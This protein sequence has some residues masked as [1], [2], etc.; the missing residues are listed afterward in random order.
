M[1]HS[2]DEYVWQVS[3]KSLH[4]AQKHCVTRNIC[5]RTDGRKDRSPDNTMPPLPVAGRG[6]TVGKIKG[7]TLL[8]HLRGFL[9]S[10]GD[11][12]NQTGYVSTAGVVV[13]AL[14][15]INEVNQRRARL[16]LRRVT[17]S[18]FNSRCRAFISV[19]NQPATQGQLSLPSLRGR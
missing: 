17:V 11:D 5:K 1:G 19:F 16:V 6:I 8:R 15:S 13:S 7:N 10:R 3:L 18:G 9:L 2:H 4:R 12:V 14:A